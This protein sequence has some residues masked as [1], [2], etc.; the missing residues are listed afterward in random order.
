MAEFTVNAQRLNAYSNFRFLV[1]WDGRAV[2][3]VSK[4]SPLKMTT[5][6]VKHRDGGGPPFPRKGKGRTEFD[7]VTL[8][9]GV[10]HD[11]EFDAWAYKVLAVGS[12]PGAD[13]SLSD[14]RK[15]IVI[16][17]LNEAGQVAIAWKL[18]RAWP[19][20]YQ[21]F[22][23]LDA[24]ANAVAIESLKLECESWERDTDVPEPQEPTVQLS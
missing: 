18:H 17:L 9:R 5:E 4:V 8:E 1:W 7:A 13:M 14:F 23:E 24:N 10:T 3:G 11:L 16:Q 22:S 2:A 21:A 19:V 20:E 12:N 6:V 15:E